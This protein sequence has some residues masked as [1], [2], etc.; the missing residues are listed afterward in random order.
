MDVKLLLEVVG[1]TVAL[2]GLVT[3]GKALRELV[4][5]NR[6]AK[7]KI[8]SDRPAGKTQAPARRAS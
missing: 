8:A 5:M 4:H 7:Q 1:A 3:A 2:V 6:V